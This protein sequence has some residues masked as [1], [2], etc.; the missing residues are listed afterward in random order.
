MERPLQRNDMNLRPPARQ[1][2]DMEAKKY[3]T[4]TQERN[5]GTGI[6]IPGTHIQVTARTEKRRREVVRACP[7]KVRSRIRIS[8]RNPCGP[9]MF[10]P[11]KNFS[12][13]IQ[14]QKRA[15]DP[16]SGSAARI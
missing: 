12:S 6:P 13:R 5:I 1:E 14:S 9:G 3:Q 8:A 11:I 4:I 15:P 16:G 7:P 2:K 10:I